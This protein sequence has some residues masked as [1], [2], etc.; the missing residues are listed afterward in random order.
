MARTN[1]PVPL[2]ARSTTNTTA[3]MP[4]G[5]P[6]GQVGGQW[7]SPPSSSTYYT[8]PTYMPMPQ[9]ESE[10]LVITD[11]DKDDIA[12]KAADKLFDLQEKEKKKEIVAV[13]EANYERE[14]KRR[15]AIEQA[16][17]ASLPGSSFDHIT[18]KALVLL[19]WIEEENC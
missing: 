13:K 19:E 10:P 12:E 5:G 16:V 7:I 6:I 1:I 15:W 2:N 9:F 11:E 3:S 18:D 14:E 17:A 8:Q 4:I